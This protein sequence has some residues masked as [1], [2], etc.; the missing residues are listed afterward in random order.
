[1]HRRQFVLLTTSAIGSAGV[2]LHTG[3]S[4]AANRNIRAFGKIFSYLKDP[5]LRKQETGDAP[6]VVEGALFNGET[7]DTQVWRNVRFVNCDFVG[8]Y[9]I[10]LDGLRHCQFESCRFSAIID[11]G[12]AQDVVFSK[13]EALGGEVNIGTEPGSKAVRFEDCK[14]EGADDRN[15]WGTMGTEGEAEYLRCKVKWFSV[16]GFARLTLSDCTLENVR[17]RTDSRASSGDAYQS[18]EVWI[19]NCKLR[20]IVEAP[21]SYLQSLTIRDTVLE[22]LDLSGATVKGD[23]VMER[24]RGGRI[25]L[26]IKENA[27][28]FRLKD[29][30][31]YGG[32]SDI[33]A[34]NYVYA[35][36]FKS[37]L[38]DNC[39]FGSDL[40]ARVLVA[41]GF[42]P[43]V[44]TPQPVITHSYVVR[45]SKFPIFDAGALNAGQV[46]LQGNEIGALDL[47]NSHIDQLELM[48]NTINR[49]VD[50]S[51]TQVKRSK[52]QSFAKGQLKLAGSNV[53]LN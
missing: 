14:F 34:T 24:V 4:M 43:N 28:N 21:S 16:F 44:K 42:D 30:Q 7:F 39:A 40:L 33:N 12:V 52:L 9:E 53:R 6:L 25:K 26:G 3:C 11:W 15:H 49:M 2:A 46:I 51:N 17:L 38:I 37:V 27:G 35:G 47:S 45:G 13:C 20:G 22:H 8:A 10:K 1:M 32:S 18:S 50:L 48:G 23:V 31:L 29:S 19:E 41:G 36:A 5:E